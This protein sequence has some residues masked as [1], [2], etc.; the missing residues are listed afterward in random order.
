MPLSIPLSEA[1]NRELTSMGTVVVVEDPLVS[2]LLRTVLRRHGYDV[3]LASP[4][5]AASLLADPD[6]NIGVLLTNTPGM[7]VEFSQRV[8]LLY[9]S[10]SPDALFEA[11]FHSCRV[12]RKPFVPEEL[13]RAVSELA[14]IVL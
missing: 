1:R 2:K 11:V 4:E 10:S 12:V 6:A 9:L 8:P 3:K 14:G 13:I 7:F 5:E